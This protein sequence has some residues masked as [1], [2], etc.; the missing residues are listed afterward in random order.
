[1]IA[2]ANEG[3]AILRMP[4]VPDRPSQGDMNQILE[5]HAGAHRP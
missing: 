1:M 5:G 2:Q 4:F 3:Q